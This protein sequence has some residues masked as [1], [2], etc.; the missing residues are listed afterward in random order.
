MFRNTLL[1]L[2]ALAVVGAAAYAIWSPTTASANSWYN[3]HHFWRPAVR[4]TTPYDG[5]CVARRVTPTPFGPRVT[6]VNVCA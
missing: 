1:A 2:A 6:H 3:H 4:F 5:N